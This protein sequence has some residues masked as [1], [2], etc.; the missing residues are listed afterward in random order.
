MAPGSMP[1]RVAFTGT[2][3]RSSRDSRVV[4]VAPE[5]AWTHRVEAFQGVPMAQRLFIGGLVFST[6]TERL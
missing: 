2:L 5:P 1:A 3:A 4:R 6:T